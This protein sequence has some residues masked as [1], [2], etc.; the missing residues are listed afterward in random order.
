MAMRT[1]AGSNTYIPSWDATGGLIAY[2]RS[3]ASFRLQQYIK[4]L[5]VK[6]DQG[7]Y[8]TLDKD[9]PAR[10]VDEDD[11]LWADGADAPIGN[12]NKQDFEYTAF[13]TVR[14][15]FAFNIGYKAA[16]QAE[17]QVVVAHAKMALQKAMTLRTIKATGLLTTAANFGTNTAAASGAWSTSS[18]AALYIQNDIQAALLAVEQSSNGII[19]SEDSFVIVMNPVTARAISV[20]PEY[21][22]FLK[23]SPFSNSYMTDRKNP[24]RVYGLAPELY[25]IK[26]VVENAMRVTSRKGVTP[27]RAFVWPNASVA[28]VSR[29]EGLVGTE[30]AE[31]SDFSTCAIRFYEENTVETKDDPDNRRHAGRVV[32]DYV[33]TLQAPTTG[34]LITSVG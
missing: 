1:P 25:G 3:A 18:E 11:H 26:V 5:N 8:L 27:T 30:G 12:A 10:I 28:L 24:N 2:T 17:W 34:Y 16:E 23:G 22:N 29:P 20:S 32:E 9:E 14:Q 13:R 33:A 15:N 7:Y 4:Y 19:Y 21:R 6:K 31:Y